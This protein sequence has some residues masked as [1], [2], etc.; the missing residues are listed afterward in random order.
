MEYYIDLGSSTIKTYTCEEKSTN[1]NLIEENS[2]S[3]KDYFTEETG[4]SRKNYILLLSYLKKLVKEYALSSQNCKIYAT[5]IW[6]KIPKEQAEILKADFSDLG[7]KFHVIS[8]EEENYYFEKAMQGIYDRKKVLMVNMGGKTTELV[9]YDKG[10]VTKRKNLSIGVGEIMNNFPEINDENQH[11]KIE[12]ILEYSLEILKDEE[13]DFGC[14][15][16]IFTGGE[17][18]YQKL[19]KYHLVPNAIFH[20]GIH[21]FM[22]SYEDLAKRNKEVLEKMTLDDLYLLM[23]KN[24]KW[25]DGAKAGSILAQAIFKKANIPYIIPSD[26]NIIHGIVKEER[27]L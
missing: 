5:G 15:C 26:L 20:D 23:P 1:P 12:D 18:R 27:K 8:Q 2:I 24:K 9:V 6:R 25:M 16:G 21:E 4:I 22:I 7:L 14:D 17:L 11:L 10:N 19:V 3:F 13:I